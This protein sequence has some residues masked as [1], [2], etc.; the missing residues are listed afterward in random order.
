MIPFPAGNVVLGSR[1]R[2]RIRELE[3]EMTKRKRDEKTLRQHTDQLEALRQIGLEITAQLDLNKLLFFIAS[4]AV[5]LLEGCSGGLYLYRPGLDL[6]E[7]TTAVGLHLSP[8]GT[9]V[10]HRGEGLAGK[11]LESN[12]AIIVD[13]YQN[14]EGKA[15]IFDDYPWTAVVAVPIRSGEEFLGVLE[16]LG[17]GPGTFSSQDAQILSLLANQAAIAVCNARQYEETS[18]RLAQSQALREVMLAATSTLDFDQVLGATCKTLETTMGVEFLTFVLADEKGQTLHLHPSYI[19][20]S[21]WDELRALPLDQSISGHVFRTGEPMIVPEV[22]EVAFYLEGSPEV[23]SEL[24]VPVRVDDQVIGVLDVESRQPNAFDEEDLVFYQAI[25][26]QLGVVLRNVR[27]YQQEQRGRQEAETLRAAALALATTLDRSE[28]VERILAQLQAVVPYDTASV[29]LLRQEGLEIVGGRG[30]PNLKEI[31]GI[32]FSL[33]GPNPNREVVHTRS[34][35][36]VADAPTTYEEFHQEPHAPAG[37]RSWLGV[38]ML[39]GEQLVGMI[40]LDKHEPG[41]YTEEHARLAEAFAA[42]AAIAIDNARLF[43]AERAVRQQAQAQAAELRV[44]ER[45]VTSLNQI[46]HSA[47]S[48]PDLQTMIETLAEQMA[49]LFNADDCYIT[50]WDEATQTTIPGAAFGSLRDSYSSRSAEPGEGTMTASVLEAE[51]PLVAEDLSNTPYIN[52]RHV[53]MS[54]NRS[55]I[56]LPL[57]AG[58][59]KLGAALIAYN[60]AHLFSTDEISRGKQAADQIALAVARAQLSQETR[61]RLKDLTV[62]F[63]TSAALSTSLDVDTV[64]KTTAQQITTALEVAGCRISLWDQEKD[65]LVMLLDYPHQVA[66]RALKAFG[67]VSHLKDYPATREI[68]LERR[69]LILRIEDPDA[70]P[71]QIAWMKEQQVKTQLI[72]PMVVRDAA[73]GAMALLECQEREFTNTEVHLSQALANQVA[74][75][76]ENARLFEETHRRATQL[77]SLNAIITEAAAVTNLSDLL[78]VA[79]ARSLEAVGLEMG[80]IWMGRHLATRNLP[81]TPNLIESQQALSVIK[82]IGA[83]TAEED[84]EA[85]SPTAGEAIAPLMS[86]LGIRAS[87]IVPITA[88]QEMAGGLLLAAPHPRPWSDQEMALTAAVGRQLGEAAERMRLLEK[89]KQQA[90]QM[91]QILWSVPEGVLL[92]DAQSRVVAAN[93]MA[94]EYLT[95]LANA[96]VGNRLSDL[97]GHP[98]AE[99]LAPPPPGLWHEIE[100]EDPSPQVFEIVARQVEPDSQEK[101]WVLVIHD[102][103]REREIHQRA[104]KRDQLAAVGQLAAGIAHDFNNILAVI[105]LYAQLSL[106]NTTIP[107]KIREN[108]ETIHQQ[109]GRAADLIQQI[110]D[111]SRSAVLKRQYLDLAPMLKEQVKLLTRTLPENIQ[112]GLHL[113]ADQCVIHADPARIQQMVMNLALNARDA[114]PDGGMLQIALHKLLIQPGQ[115]TPLSELQSGEWAVIRISDSGVGIPTEVKPHIFTPFFT[116]KPPGKGTGLGLSQVYGIVKQHGGHIDVSSQTGKGSIFTIYF[117]TVMVAQPAARSGLALARLPEGAGETILVVEDNPVTREAVVDGLRSLNYRVVEAGNGREALALMDTKNQVIGVVLTDLVM[118]V[119]GGR[120][121][122]QTLAEQH[123]TVQIIAMTGHPLD[124]HTEELQTWNVAGWLQKPLSLEKLA[125]VVRRVV[126]RRNE[127]LP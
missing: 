52:P 17:D 3:Q 103:T 79:L 66:Q 90:Q 10:L 25:A 113:T 23:R 70:D 35:F 47:L 36:I 116:T 43:E 32:T 65:A 39:V 63:N 16:V 102:A 86:Q 126:P 97:G 87:I 104:Q 78:D 125:Q 6:L 73:I 19:G 27:L 112:I 15:S 9:I 34:S 80:G 71:A 54:Q 64:L 121:L 84:W 38:P 114:M 24:A 58:K 18:R 119:M 127:P 105:V 124:D 83:L 91:E 61:Q 95:I 106:R 123:P 115:H 53:R 14:W 8:G 45:F 56:G 94:Q 82:Q 118:P 31:V 60:Q 30:F 42:Q 92:L 99:L 57:I 107:N 55:M 100:I 26:G 21:S 76:I 29:Q 44:R 20:F 77:D 2:A 48:T 13:D 74:I 4:R 108:L 89:I 11:V 67:P 101:G 85:V 59:Q 41:F 120:Q 5:A 37:I 50:L 46:T 12:Q 40:A 69:P 68:L 51:R 81:E 96:Q 117:P 75:G 49:N 22:R 62:L 110:L 122:I 93:P 88:D 33:D 98:L 7:W 28:V 111:F 109:A 72:I 1:V